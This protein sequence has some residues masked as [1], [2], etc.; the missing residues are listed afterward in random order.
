MDQFSKQK[1]LEIRRGLFLVRY[2]AADNPNDPPRFQISVDPAAAGNVEL[3]LPPEAI[4]AILWSPGACF[5]VRAD[6]PGRLNVAVAPSHPNGS[7]AGRVQLIGLSND[8]AGLQETQDPPG[9]LDLSG[10]RL[11]G[12]V[13]GVGDVL[14]DCETWI[15]G[16]TSPSRIEGIAVQ[17]PGKPHDLSLR[18]AVTVGGPRPT[19]GQFVEAGQYAG[20]KGRALPLVGTTLEISGRGAVG[21]RL[22]VEGIFLGSPQ[23]KVAGQRV[24]LAGP[25]GREPL[26]GLRVRVET[27][28]QAK[29]AEHAAAEP[30]RSDD[31]RAQS[32]RRLVKRYGAAPA[33][34][35]ELPPNPTDKDTLR[36]AKRSGQVRVFRSAARSTGA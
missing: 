12:H 16:P 33:V 20:T 17:W 18:Y 7:T 4:D 28:V 11:L 13:A 24:V 3:I 6:Q 9:E 14:V 10:F 26:V 29:K 27:V 35:R 31:E 15:A 8:P 32:D 25:T 1:S 30:S 23:M 36:P 5:V 22:A 34:G 19:I 21:R 2:E